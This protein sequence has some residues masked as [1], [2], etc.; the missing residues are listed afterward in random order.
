MTLL[1]ITE[2]K[3]NTFISKVNQGKNF[4]LVLQQI[5]LALK[6]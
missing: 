3:N 5:T 1:E 4:L 6:I 2:R